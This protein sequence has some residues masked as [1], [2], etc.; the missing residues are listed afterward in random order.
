[1]K[2]RKL[3]FEVEHRARQ[4]I[5]HGALT[6]SKRPESFVKGVYPTHLK[7]GYGCRVVDTA[8]NEYVDFVA[9]L[10]TNLLGYGQD[11]ITQAIAAQARLGCSLSLGTELEVKVAEKLKEFFPFVDRVRF[12]KTGSEAATAACIIA[13]AY[14]RNN[15][16]L[17]EGYHGFHPEFTSLTPPAYGVTTHRFIKKLE[18][19][20]RLAEPSPYRPAAVIVEPIVTDRTEARIQWLKDLR[21]RCTETGV[22]LIFDE[23]ITGFRFPNFSAAQQFDVMPDL[24]CLGKAV[25]GGMPLSIVGGRADIMESDYFV[26]STF[27]GETV[28]LAAALKFLELLQ[29]KKFSLD[30]LCAK[31]NE[32]QDKFN[33]IRPEI[34]SLQGYGTRGV[35]VGSDL[36]KA[37]FMQECAKAGILIGPSFFFTF[38]HIEIM[39][40]VL[41]T[42]AD[43]LGRIHLGE[44]KIEGDLPQK[45]YAQKVREK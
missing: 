15:E 13:R 33:K 44:V 22:L 36:N 42:M 20:E 19:L 2:S 45:P 18:S 38:P 28:S 25:G 43:I 5:A 9:G 24:I 27:A 37:L 23:I 35:F 10:G 34:V 40:Q 32:F 39:E 29:S 4:C 21:K 12:L 14:T 31:A 3:D 30:Y 17:S 7:H 11:E 6:N 41:S 8:G 26:S 1:M 16:I